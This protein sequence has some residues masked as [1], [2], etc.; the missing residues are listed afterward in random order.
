M[1]RTLRRAV[2][3]ATAAM[4]LSLCSCYTARPVGD[5]RTP[6][7]RVA[8][9]APQPTA[10]PA[11]TWRSHANPGSS[12]NVNPQGAG[13]VP[14]PAPSEIRPIGWQA[15]AGPA[16][17]VPAAFTPADPRV[18][19]PSC[20]DAPYGGPGPVMGPVGPA[21]VMV[22]PLPSPWL[23]PDE[24][25]CD[26][27]D[28]GLPV[29]YDTIHR[30]GLETEDTVAEYVDDKGGF[31]VAP[32]NKVCVY[33]PRFGAVRTVSSPVADVGVDYAVGADQLASGVN[34][35]AREVSDL[36]LQNERAGSARVRSRASGL[37]TDVMVAGATQRMAVIEHQKLINTYQDLQFFRTGEFLRT[38]EARLAIGIQAAAVWTRLESPTIVAK[39]LQGQSIK[40]VFRA[41][42]LVGVEDKKVPGV[43]RIV[44]LAD[45]ATA[46]PGDVITFT[47][48]YDN[49][50]DLEVF[51]TQIVDNLTPR[52]EYIEDSVISDRPGD[53]ITEP[54]GEGSLVLKFV[55]DDPIQ[56]H[57]GGVITFKA[58]VR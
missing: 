12:L 1:G 49:V 10:A 15:E 42:E 50:G 21:G 39:T 32:T 41:Q 30:L 45:R 47:L 26:G 18:P 35:R 9:N 11:P 46:Q 43:L 29:H 25:L 36:H 56:G 57:T 13:P 4:T 53:I 24:Y 52:L 55:L 22:Q 33:A 27:G 14:A 58:R 8:S 31:H 2:C 48:R 20:P 51:H 23:Y 40:S 44:K 6:Q 16:S 5:A 38:E 3:C 37:A 34:L 7:V 19:C 17:V 28:R 54:N